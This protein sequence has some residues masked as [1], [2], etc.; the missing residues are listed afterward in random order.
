MVEEIFQ[1]S[2]TKVK[3]FLKPYGKVTNFSESAPSFP[4]QKI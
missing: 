3:E 1:L 2:P 4:M